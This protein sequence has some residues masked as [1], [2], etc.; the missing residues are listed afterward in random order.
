[1]VAGLSSALLAGCGSSGDDQAPAEAAALWQR[2]HAE[3]YRELPRAPGY[4]GRTP[5]SAAHGD[6]VDIYVNDK[7]QQ[8]L[9]TPGLTA[10]PDGSLI[11]KDGWAGPSLKFVAAMEKRG[12]KWFWVEWDEDGDAKYSGAPSLCTGCHASG[13]DFVRAF[14]LT[15]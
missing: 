14:S 6:S 8:A 10:W 3:R 1:M 4:P 13:S 11:V 9:A 15:R 12:G 7:V 2:I 5:S